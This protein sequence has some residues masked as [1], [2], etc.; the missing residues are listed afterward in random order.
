MTDAELVKAL[1]LSRNHGGDGWS[2]RSQ[3]IAAHWDSIERDL[4]NPDLWAFV[5]AEP[6]PWPTHISLLLDTRAE[7]LAEAPPGPRP[8]FFTFETL[9][10]EITQPGSKF[11]DRV[12][13]LHSLIV[14]WYEDRNLYHKI[15]Y[16]VATG[17]SFLEMVN[18]ARDK[19]KSEFD[20]ALSELI[21]TD[22]ALKA[23]DV[24]D[25]S[26]NV[27]KEKAKCA[28]LLLLMNVEATRRMQDS[29]ERYSFQRHA[30]GTW[31]LEHIHA[32]SAESLNRAEQWTAWLKAHQSA[33]LS[34]PDATARPPGPRS[35]DRGRASLDYRGHLPRPGA[36][37]GRVLP[38][39]AGRRR[40]GHHPLDRQPRPAGH[41]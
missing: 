6:D 16:L 23:S 22:L 7:L 15:G 21:R 27:D 2:S 13:D 35:T 40:R 18:L 25:L 41:R 39:H 29:T 31:S 36:Q 32:Q 38:Q 5:T 34:L 9:R 11:W 24:G 37:G 3:E 17:H 10:H 20:R 33:L 1:L 14:G 30:E 28:D 4:R 8:Q 19:T 12:V 26:Y